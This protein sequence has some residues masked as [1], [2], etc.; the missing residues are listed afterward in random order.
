MIQQLF[1]TK[2]IKIE[3]I[4]VFVVG[5]IFFGKVTLGMVRTLYR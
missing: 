3:T 5:Y 2:E 1:K 4:Y